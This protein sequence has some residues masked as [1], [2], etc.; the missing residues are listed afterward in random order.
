MAA[1]LAKIGKD[2]GLADLAYEQLG[3]SDIV[4]NRLIYGAM[5]KAQGE[6]AARRQKSAEGAQTEDD[7]SDLSKQ[8]DILMHR[9]VRAYDGACTARTDNAKGFRENVFEFAGREFFVDHDANYIVPDEEV[10]ANRFALDGKVYLA[11]RQPKTRAEL[12]SDKVRGL[13]E[14]YAYTGVS[15]S[16]DKF[17]QDAIYAA[18]G[19]TMDRKVAVMFLA[20]MIAEARRNPNAHVTN[21][22]LMKAG[23]TGPFFGA[24]PMTTGGTS[25]AEKFRDPTLADKVQ[26]GD[27]PP[28]TVSDAEIALVRREYEKAQGMTVEEA[29]TTLGGEPAFAN[30]LYEFLLKSS[31]LMS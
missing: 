23:G 21:L 24:A 19:G 28:M 8:F 17:K 7:A 2:H 16:I 25:A 27:Q 18:A 26:A 5:A 22:L 3:V 29:I 4:L 6:I 12:D 14:N 10:G 30:D 1:A 31:H 9:T 15:T 13:I 20:G 11:S